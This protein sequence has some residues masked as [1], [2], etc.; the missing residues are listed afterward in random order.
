M[1]TNCERTCSN[2]SAEKPATSY[3]CGSLRLRLRPPLTSNVE[4]LQ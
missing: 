2:N 3:A 4:R 1:L